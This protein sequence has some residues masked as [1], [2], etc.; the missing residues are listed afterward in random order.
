MKLKKIDIRITIYTIISI[1][2]AYTIQ[3]YVFSISYS[4]DL[5]AAFFYSILI[6][7]V[8]YGINYLLNKYGLIAKSTKKDIWL[9]TYSL[10]IVIAYYIVRTNIAYEGFLHF[11]NTE[12]DFLLFRLILVLFAFILSCIIN[13]IFLAM[14][15]SN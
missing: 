3:E 6:L 7:I 13:G 5:F 8:L 1:F 12:F 14:K 9:I 15:K 11:T 2:L 4:P 10:I